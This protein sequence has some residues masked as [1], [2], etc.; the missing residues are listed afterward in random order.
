M[1]VH[2][3]EHAVVRNA[4][5][6]LAGRVVGMGLTA[7]SSVVLFRYLGSHLLGEYSSVYAYLALFGW[8]ATFGMDV[9]LARDLSRR[10]EAAATIIAA[11]MVLGLALSVL[12]TSIALVAAPSVGYENVLPLLVLASLE[13]LILT[14][15]RLPSIVL[16]VDLRQWIAVAVGVG[17]QVLWL[18][19][20]VV[21]TEANVSLSTLVLART[22]CATL[23]V[24]ILLV[25]SFQTVIPKWKAIWVEGRGILVQ[26][27]PLALTALA[28]GVY[29]RVD[30]VMLHGLAGDAELGHYV[31]AVNLVELLGAI[32]VAF[33]TSLFPTLSRVAGE[34]QKF[35][36]H[37]KDGFRYLMAVACGLSLAIAVGSDVVVRLVYGSGFRESSVVLAILVWSELPVF[38]GIVAANALIAVGLQRFLPIAAIAGAISNLALNALLIPRLG[39][40]GAAW[41]SV[42]SYAVGGVGIFVVLRTTRPVV[43]V[44]LRVAAASTLIA[45][46]VMALLTPLAAAPSLKVFLALLAYVVGLLVSQTIEVSDIRRVWTAIRPDGIGLR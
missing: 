5:V 25:V 17:R 21:L 39:G 20:V 35:Q 44:G 13:I 22:A 7:I 36:R 37:V 11:A 12:A 41:A 24:L 38:W 26:A 2:S 32:P 4:L 27:A 29:H 18:A 15:L 43:Q 8:L 30:Q 34:R 42:I 9:V 33:M 23:E 14:P 19:M 3:T 6:L 40:A 16:Q 45:L 46:S 31:A 10:R 1:R 28:V